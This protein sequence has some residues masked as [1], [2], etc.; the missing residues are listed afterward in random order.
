MLTGWFKCP[1]VAWQWVR[2]VI[3]KSW[4]Y[5]FMVADVL[6]LAEIQMMEMAVNEDAVG[7]KLVDTALEILLEERE[8][9]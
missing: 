2:G 8:D 4:A 1:V 3:P 7:V 9:G 6:A 5:D